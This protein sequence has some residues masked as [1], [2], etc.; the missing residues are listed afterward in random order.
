MARSGSFDSIEHDGVVQRSD[1]KS[2]TVRILSVSACAGCHAEGSCN[3][4]AMEEKFVDIPG[5]FNLRPGDHVT[6]VMK[7]SAGYAAVLLGYGFPLVLL[8]VVM[9]IL[10]SMKV[11][12]LVTG[13]GSLAVLLPY[14]T[15]LWL[16]RKR[17]GNKFKF[18]I[19]A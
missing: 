17:I 2:I 12:E 8:I 19:K 14:Y 11:S 4:S 16:F 10:S 13:L 15:I 3:L 5:I 7:R 1:N 18:S 9:I 6:V